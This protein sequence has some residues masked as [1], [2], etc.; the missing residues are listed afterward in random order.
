[1]FVWCALPKP[2]SAT[3]LF[4]KA[5]QANV[6]YVTGSA[7]HANGGG[8]E[9]LRLNFTNSTPGQIEEGIKRLGEVFSKAL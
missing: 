9:T 2:L 3:R 8:D 7:F 1:M 4:Q 5:I 6:A